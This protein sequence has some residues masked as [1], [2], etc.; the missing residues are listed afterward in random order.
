[1]KVRGC[2]YVNPKWATLYLKSIEYVLVEMGITDKMD[3]EVAF[4]A[5]IYGNEEYDLSFFVS[6]RKTISV[7][8]WSDKCKIFCQLEQLMN[9]RADGGYHVANGFDFIL[10]IFR[11]NM[12]LRGTQKVWY[13]PIGYTPTWERPKFRRPK[14]SRTRKDIDVLFWGNTSIREKSLDFL[15][16]N[17]INVE[18]SSNLYG[19]ELY[20]CIS[21]SKIIIWLKHTNCIDY[22]QL[23]C[24]PAQ[25]EFVL[26]EKSG[27]YGLFV[28]GLDFEIFEDR[29][30]LLKK[31]NYYLEHEKERE[32]FAKNAYKHLITIPYSKSLQGVICN[33]LIHII[34]Q[35]KL[36]KKSEKF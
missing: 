14:P 12:K 28:P 3:I 36:L 24:L 2:I 17:G 25:G 20:E 1:M 6:G 30:D 22:A 4:D 32:E 34:E 35:K 7:K 26:V 18:Y 19:D 23:H 33:F 8:D 15:K 10:E 11:E 29:D 5:P 31:I 21:H 13:C 27:D 16:D 9:C